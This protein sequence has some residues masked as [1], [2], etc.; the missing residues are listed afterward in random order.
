VYL[1]G[2]LVDTNDTKI[3]SFIGDHTKTSIGT[4]LNTGTVVG[5]MSNVITSGGMTPKFIP[6]FTMFLD[7]KMYNIPFKK[8]VETART[9][10]GRR[11]RQLTD[12]EVKLLQ[13][14]LEV[15]KA[16]RDELV[17]RSRKVLARER[18]LHD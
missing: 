9:A 11:K 18:G 13:A 8:T 3:G 7:N 6:S 1:K 12:C 2:E 15:T 10:M 17:R 5:C 14:A 4:V 16:E